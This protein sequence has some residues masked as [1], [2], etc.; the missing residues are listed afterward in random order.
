M[1]KI[2]TDILGE[3]P[4][5]KKGNRYIL[6]I[7]DYFTKLT[8]NLFMPNIEDA[9]VHRIIVEKVVVHYGTLSIAHSDQGR[10][11]EA[12]CSPRC[13]MSCT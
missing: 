5:T 8:E 12:S 10:Q 1:D 13:S 6:V 4:L 11:Y 7:S 9:T 3:R 2:A